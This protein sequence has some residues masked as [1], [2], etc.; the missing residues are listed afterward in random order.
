MKFQTKPKYRPKRLEFKYLLSL[1]EADRI[2]PAL[3]RIMDWDQHAQDK[4]DQSYQVNSLYFDSPTLKNYYEKIAG[5]KKRKKFRVR[6]YQNKVDDQTLV[7]LECK[8]KQGLVIKKDRVAQ[9]WSL[10][11]AF[12]AGQVKVGD[13]PQASQ[14]LLMEFQY[15]KRKY[16]MKPKTI[17]SYSRRALVGRGKNNLRVT[18]D[19]GL[20]ALKMPDLKL[21][22]GSRKIMTRHLVLEIKCDNIIPARVHEIIQQYQLVH[23]PHSKYCYS[24][25]RTYCLRH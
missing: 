5:I 18:F 21:L 4:Q 17:V 23:G 1:R 19:S 25:D 8:R 7:F 14:Q 20:S 2:I 10:V 12:L 6:Y 3:L 16:Q 15:E 13:F 9:P 11:R 24:I 22:S